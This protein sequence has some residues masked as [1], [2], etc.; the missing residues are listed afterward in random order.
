[1]LAIIPLPPTL[2]VATKRPKKKEKGKKRKESYEMK[3]R[4]TFYCLSL[5]PSFLCVCVGYRGELTP[6]KR[7][8][9]RVSAQVMLEIKFRAFLDDL[10]VSTNS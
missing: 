3:T 8:S 1:M 4:V 5:F 6:W 9:H 2:V 10:I 7:I